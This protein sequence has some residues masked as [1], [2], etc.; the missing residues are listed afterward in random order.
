MGGGRGSAF[1]EILFSLKQTPMLGFFCFF[2]T[3]PK[4]FILSYFL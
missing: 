2:V 4:G 1:K 3:Y